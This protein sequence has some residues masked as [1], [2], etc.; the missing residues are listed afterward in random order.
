MKLIKF[1]K[2]ELKLFQK[3]TFAIS[4][5][6][7]KLYSFKCRHV[8]YILDL[9]CDVI[10]N[11]KCYIFTYISV[12]KYGC[13]GATGF[14][15]RSEGNFDMWLLFY[16]NVGLRDLKVLSPGLSTTPYQLHHLVSPNSKLSNSY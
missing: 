1:T 6:V 16:R 9:N 7:L 2:I 14:L 8:Q 11:L 5:G 13:M 4:W 12:Y 10:L 3:I 15:C